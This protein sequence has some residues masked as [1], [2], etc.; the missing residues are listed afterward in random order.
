MLSAHTPG[1]V[2]RVKERLAG[3]P[4]TMK[5][6]LSA[7]LQIGRDREAGAAGA[8]PVVPKLINV[9]QPPP[10]QKTVKAVRIAVEE[11]EP[12]QLRAATGWDE[13]GI[14][15]DLGTAL[16]ALQEAYRRLRVID[17]K[18]LSESVWSGIRERL[19]QIDEVVRWFNVRMERED[20]WDDEDAHDERVYSASESDAP[21]P[22]TATPDP[23][24][25][26]E[27]TLEVF[28]DE[29]TSSR[30]RSN[31]RL[32]ELIILD[33][34][35]KHPAL[36]DAEIAARAMASDERCGRVTEE[37]VAG[38]RARRKPAGPVKLKRGVIL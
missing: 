28:P 9:I 4:M 27:M 37:Y 29:K 14:R 1:L 6:A 18:T 38:V 3:Q 24:E 7:I 8:V 20:F 35:E 23:A 32:R 5:A 22:L 33:E 26:A 16:S 12:T 19:N 13:E 34:I 15:S 30:G 31:P 25:N 10:I 36:T 2:A 11:P 17:P 21:P